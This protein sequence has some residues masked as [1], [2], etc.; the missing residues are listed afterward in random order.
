[1]FLIALYYSN[2]TIQLCATAVATF[3]IIFSNS[4]LGTIPALRPGL[5]S[6]PA[7]TYDNDDMLR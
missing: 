7:M 3:C 6:Y 4:I 2:Y 1:M 5:S